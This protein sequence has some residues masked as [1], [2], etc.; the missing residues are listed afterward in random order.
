MKQTMRN[1][2]VGSLLAL[3]LN[4]ALAQ[5]AEI[6]KYRPL[7]ELVSGKAQAVA[8]DNK[9]PVIAWGAD[10][11]T[12]L[13]VSEN[14]LPSVKLYREDNF[15]IQVGNCIKGSS[16][17]LRGTLPMI[18]QARSAFQKAGTDLVLI[19]QLTHKK[20]PDLFLKQK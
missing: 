11:A 1:F 8:S 16:P 2:I 14:I 13:A 10:V 4:S 6:L 17:Y 15:P 19:Y 9:L 3:G 7:D 5:K 20:R 12:Q 18:L